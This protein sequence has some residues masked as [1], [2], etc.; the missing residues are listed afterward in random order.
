[1]SVTGDEKLDYGD[2]RRT[3]VRYRVMAFLCVLAFLTY[4]DRICIMRA[5]GDIQRDLGLSD[6]EMGLVFG[7]FSLAY[8]LFEIPSGWLGDRFGARGALTR[9]V[10]AWSIFSAATG[11]A[12]GFVTLWTYRFLFGVGE[13]GAFPNMARIQSRWLAARTRGRAGGLL[14]LTARWG[15]AFSPL[16]FGT[17]LRGV[18][19]LRS[20]G[21]LLHVSPWRVGF[22]MSGMLGAVWVVSFYPW[23]RDDPADV[24]AVNRRELEFIH[25]G[26]GPDVGHRHAVAGVWGALFTSGSLWAIALMYFTGGFGW[27]FFMSWMPRFLKEVHHVKFEN[28]EL[29]NAMPLFFG[30]MSCLTGGWL[31]DKLV[32]RTG[33]KRLGR[34]VFPV[35]GYITAAVAMFCI[36]F[37]HSPGQAVVLM[38]VAAGAFDFGQGSNWATI[39]DI[40]GRFAGSAAGFINMVGNMAGF[41]QPVLGAMIFNHF[42]WNA[43]FAVYSGA[44]LTAS[45]MWSFIDPNRTFYEDAA[46]PEDRGFE[47]VAGEKV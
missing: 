1:M 24:P 29:M 4:F 17:I 30:G 18:D 34:A 36:R 43:L 2:D 22:W 31:S 10:L 15:G 32:K 16:I 20:R 3:R 41:L 37:V 38:C 21:M 6:A 33:R 8:A 9:I 46:V 40:G 44:F 35:S 19:V 12:T 7:A 25:A 42:G 13:A 26:R 5:Q 11:A 14:W 39:V 28:S 23:F 27:S 45:C 47:V